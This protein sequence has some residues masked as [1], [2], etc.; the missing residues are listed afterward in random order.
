[1]TAKP[2]L[3]GQPPGDTEY[4]ND[5]QVVSMDHCGTAEPPQPYYYDVFEGHRRRREAAKRLPPLPHSGRRDPLT[6]AQIADCRER[7]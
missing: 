2:V 3:P 6:Y 5:D 7:P 1:M 4:E